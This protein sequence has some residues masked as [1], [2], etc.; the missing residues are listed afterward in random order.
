MKLPGN[1]V[2]STLKTVLLVDDEAD[3]VQAMSF[4]L[5]RKGITVLTAANGL[6]ALKVL[7]ESLVKPQ[8]ILLDGNMPLMNAK[9]FLATRMSENIHPRVPV[10]LLSSDLWEV[11][12]PSIL[13]HVPKPFDLI[14]L[15]ERMES[16]FPSKPTPAVLG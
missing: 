7:Q 3:I 16:F 2:M 12:D 1:D 8:L 11:D 10:I 5:K 14:N 13:C 6:E 15:I 4:F 9:E